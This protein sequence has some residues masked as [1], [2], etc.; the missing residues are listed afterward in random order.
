[1]F[2]EEKRSYTGII[3]SAVVL[4]AL[5]AGGWWYFYH[6]HNHPSIEIK[7]TQTAVAPLRMQYGH[8]QG[9]GEDRQEDATYIVAQVQVN[10]LSDSPFFI[11]DINADFTPHGADPV[12]ISAIQ[13][14][15]VPRLIDGLPQV[16]DAVGK[17][18]GSLLPREL[19]IE[20][21]KSASGYVVLQYPGE[22]KAW[23]GRDEAT[24]RIDFYHN[25]YF[26]API[27]K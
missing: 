8:E 25:A 2:E 12:E 23:D 27:P 1:M 16:K 11:K 26:T 3:I 5:A 21:H 15:D 22:Q 17:V 18:G 10:N 9:F 19:K 20:P 14:N 7:V 13:N 4:V 24:L 6:T